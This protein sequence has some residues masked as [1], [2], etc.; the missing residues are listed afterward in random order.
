MSL[1]AHEPNTPI[2]GGDP[3]GLKTLPDVLLKDGD[4]VGSLLAV[5]S[6]GHTPGSMAFL[7][8]RTKALTDG[9]RTIDEE[10]D[11]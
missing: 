4:Q 7:D 2:K 8:V 11:R 1:D 9:S 10:I 5:S 3:K 6:P